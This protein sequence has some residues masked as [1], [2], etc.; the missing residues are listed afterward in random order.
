M[1]LIN[2][3]GISFLTPAVSAAIHRVPEEYSTIQAAIDDAHHG[4]TILVA[5]GTYRENIVVNKRVAIIGENK[6][7]TI[8]DGAGVGHVVTIAE[9]GVEIRGFTIRNGGTEYNGIDIMTVGNA[10]I[11][12]NV[13]TENVAGIELYQSDGNTIV[14]NTFFNNSIYG[15][16]VFYSLGNNITGNIVSESNYGIQLDVSNS[17]FVVR[18]LISNTSYGIYVTHSSNIT[19]SDNVLLENSFGIL[20]A[21]SE[22][23]TVRNNRVEGSTYGI[24]VY[25]STNISVINNTVSDNPSYAIYLVHSNLNLLKGNT[26][27][28]NDWAIQ[29]YNSTS[30]TI[31]QNLI[32]LNVY[33]IYLASGSGQNTFYHNNIIDNVDQVYVDLFI[34]N[35]WDNGTHGNYWSDYTG[36]DEN[37]DGIG[38]TAYTI[39]AFNKDRY[40][41]MTEWGGIHDVAIVNITL[42]STDVRQGEIVYIN[43]T[44][45]NEGTWAETFNVTT[46]Y[47]NT[48]IGT[49]TV[50]EL[51][52]GADR[53]LTFSWNTADV[54]PGNYTIMA[55]ASAVMSENDT[56]DNIYV[57]G[58]VAVG[59]VHDVAI[60]KI[61]VDPVSAYPGQPIYVNV[62]VENRGHFTETFNVTV[63]VDKNLT[64]IGD[65]VTLGEQTV[66][67]LAP[68]ANW[69]LSFIWNTSDASPGNY[70]VSAE[71]DVVPGETDTVNNVLVGG[72][73]IG[74]IY[75]RYRPQQEVNTLALLTPLVFAILIV[76]AMGT[77][78][79]LLFRFL[80]SPRP[81]FPR[82]HSRKPRQD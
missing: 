76:T 55:Q 20:P 66:Y 23:I 53:I 75:P 37:G 48:T 21:Y 46:K 58:V 82:I 77:I 59:R 4:D 8:I 73:F 27:L 81:R 47:D 65:E 56:A 78:A 2:V 17:T 9:S 18:N 68:R 35:T 69:T 54:D 7:N 67:D 64:V 10:L 31:I 50:N 45:V 25:G 12:D 5:N 13:L 70:W 61:E 40:P 44:A 41:L 30:N 15:L 42:S 24:E 1:L 32:S 52:P 79:V 49:Q 39:N 51:A 63:Y 57:D 16:K 36:T 6:S 11:I 72:T 26:A 74:G 80:M 29:L 62:T 60:T 34:S 43:V 3:L 38:D 14:G 71:A 22:D 19:V 33:G 28:R